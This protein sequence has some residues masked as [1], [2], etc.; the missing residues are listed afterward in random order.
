MSLKITKVQHFKD[1]Q[2][3]DARQRYNKDTISI[4]KAGKRINVYDMIQANNVDT[5]IYKVAAKY[6]MVNR[7]MECAQTYMQH[8]AVQLAEELQEYTDLRGVMDRQ[9]KAKQ[10]WEGLPLELR[11]KFN[12]DIYQ[13][14]DNGPK[15]I[16]NEIQRLQQPKTE[17]KK[18]NEP[19]Q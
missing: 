12:N 10:L 2:M 16:Q 3:H 17:V 14:M 19:Q 5:D 1:A 18:T 4:I 11:A 13:F 7:E 6:G 9:I 8:N 15:W